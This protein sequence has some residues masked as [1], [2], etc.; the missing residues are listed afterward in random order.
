MAG[1]FVHASRLEG[2]GHEQGEEDRNVR[3]RFFAFLNCCCTKDHIP[4][5][6]DSLRAQE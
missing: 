2:K 1:T 3:G 6:G 5:E 4:E